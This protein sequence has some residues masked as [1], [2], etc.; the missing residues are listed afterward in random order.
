M[1]ALW[2]LLGLF[3]ICSTLCINAFTFHSPEGFALHGAESD[4]RRARCDGMSCKGTHPKSIP[5]P[6]GRRI[7]PEASLNRYE[8][9]GE[10]LMSLL[11]WNCPLRMKQVGCFHH[12]A[13]W[14]WNQRGGVCHSG[15]GPEP[16]GC[17]LEG[18]VGV[19]PGRFPGAQSL[20]A[21]RESCWRRKS[22]CLRMGE[23]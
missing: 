13:L 14:P 18:T 22:P 21:S 7:R 3:I 4:C 2:P 17:R 15:M 9:S 11:V 12:S 23:L 19:Y 1:A 20:S 5:A 6:E 10:N 8:T 16:V